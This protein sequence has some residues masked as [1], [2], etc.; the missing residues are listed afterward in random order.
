MTFNVSNDWHSIKSDP[1]HSICDSIACSFS[2][3]IV[4]PVWPMFISMC[5]SIEDCHCCTWYWLVVWSVLIFT[6][7][8]T[9]LQRHYHQEWLSWS[10]F[11]LC[12]PWKPDNLYLVLLYSWARSTKQPYCRMLFWHRHDVPASPCRWDMNW[13]F[14]AWWMHML[15]S[16]QPLGWWVVYVQASCCPKKL[17]KQY[18]K[19]PF[20][21]CIHTCC[22]NYLYIHIVSL[23]FSGTLVENTILQG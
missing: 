19:P 13:S 6:L 22:Y 18:S 23:C 9:I 7:P 15:S 10:C 17:E 5:L 21:K 12:L 14:T 4:W 8:G 16:T 3:H 1:W 2:Q 11:T 20:K